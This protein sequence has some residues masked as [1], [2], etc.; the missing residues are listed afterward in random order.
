MAECWLP[1][2]LPAAVFAQVEGLEDLLQSH[3]LGKG[4]RCVTKQLLV[5]LPD[6]KMKWR[7][8]KKKKKIWAGSKNVNICRATNLRWQVHLHRDIGWPITHRKDVHSQLDVAR[9]VLALHVL[10]TQEGCTD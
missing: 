8:K 2:Q 1:L 10:Q 9:D 7:R 4:N 5:Y 3:H 6:E